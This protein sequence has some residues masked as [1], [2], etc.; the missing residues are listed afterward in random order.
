MDKQW[1]QHRTHLKARQALRKMEKAEG[2]DGF[3][4]DQVIT[5]DSLRQVMNENPRIK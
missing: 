1:E 3:T 2:K 5:M 4:Y